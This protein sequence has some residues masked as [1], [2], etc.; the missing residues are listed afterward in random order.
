MIKR[1]FSD[2]LDLVL[3]GL[4][5]LGLLRGGPAWWRERIRRRLETV[6]TETE[7]LRRSVRAAH[8]MCRECRALVPSRERVC[9]ECG[10]SMTG[11]PR[12]GLGRLASTLLP[13]FG[14]ASLTLVGVI[15]TLFVAMAMASAEGGLRFSVP[16]E[17]LYQLGGKWREDILFHGQ[18]WRLVNPIFLH[19]GLLHIGFNAYAL[20]NLGPVVEGMLGA[21][22]F[23]VVFFVCGVFSFIVSSWWSP[24]SF[25]V[26]A[27]GALFGL[28]G[29]GITHGYLRGG[30]LGRN[31][32]RDL[33]RWALLGVLMALFPLPID[34]A[35]HAGGFIAGC[36]LGW[37]ISGRAPRSAFGERAWSLAAVLAVLIPLL[38]FAMA[39]WQLAAQSS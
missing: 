20:A 31:L 38:G 36:L 10:A 27:S 4:A 23:L 28:I 9:P 2:T 39:I 13:G 37:M 35:A 34:N 24:R 18:W 32:A 3:E 26:G 6:S 21:R 1:F 5:R 14:S 22:R 33:V 7:T 29:F 17:L 11:I 16:T 25:G 19:A 30:A 8:R 15:V 12:G